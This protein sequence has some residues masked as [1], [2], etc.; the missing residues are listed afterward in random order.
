[1]QKIKSFAKVNLSLAVL[2]RRK[3]NLH[4]IESLFCFINLHDEIEIIKSKNISHK[5]IFFG[6]F[7]KNIGKN[8]TISKLLKNL[9][10]ESILNNQKYI[11]KVNKNIPI[12]SGLGGGSM[13]AASILK[14][15]VN[16]KA[17]KIGKAQ[18]SKICK[19]IGSDVLLGI[20]KKPS[21]L[22]GNE[23]IFRLSGKTN[24]HCV[25]VKPRFGCST[26]L[27]YKGIKFYSKSKFK[28]PGKI[29]FNKNF[30]K[31]LD[32]DLEKIAFKK[33]PSLA[34]LKKEME[35]IGKFDFVRMTGSGSCIVGY[36]TSKKRC[37]NAL[38]LIKKNYNNHWCIISK[39]I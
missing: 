9:D 39:T 11:I 18:L 17:I 37:L 35:K 27:I 23:K 31:T 21:I 16:K 3:N 19:S 10:K 29:K 8:N 25:L 38:K 34:S 13:N 24:F 33:Y 7:S 6:K 14:Y 22:T 32:N 20:K 30:I 15:F 2:S 28:K 1:M 4:K 36:S 12:K 5:I 26:K